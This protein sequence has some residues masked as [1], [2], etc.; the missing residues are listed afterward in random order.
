V[1]LSDDLGELLR[2]IFT[3]QDGVTHEVE[4]KI[5]RD[6]PARITGW[7]TENPKPVAEESRLANG[8]EAR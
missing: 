5:I 7:K 8:R 2:A 4:E 1:F 3:G 6:M